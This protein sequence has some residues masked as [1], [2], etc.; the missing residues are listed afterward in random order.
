MLRTVGP[1]T[2]HRAAAPAT[3][4]S[5][6]R[7][8]WRTARPWRCG[9]ARCTTAPRTCSSSCGG[10]CGCGRWV[11]DRPYD[12]RAAAHRARGAG[13][14]SRGRRRRPRRGRAA[15]SSPRRRAR[16]A[17]SRTGSRAASRGGPAPG[18]SDDGHPSTRGP[19]RRPAGPGRSTGTLVLDVWRQVAA[20]HRDR[21]AHRNLDL[22]RVWVTPEGQAVLRGFDGAAIAA[23]DRDLALDRAQ[24]LVSTALVIGAP[25][26]R[27]TWRW[28]RSGRHAVMTAVPYLQP[29]ALPGHDPAGVARQQGGARRPAGRDRPRHRGRSRRRWPASTA[30]GPARRCRS[31][32]SRSPSTCCSRSS[33]T[34]ATTVDAASEANWWWLAPMVLGAA[35]TIVFAALAFVAS[36]P[37]PIPYLPAL[38]MQL[39][40]SFVS[41][42]A[43]ANTGHAGGRRAVPAAVGPRPRAGGGRGRADARCRASSSTCRSWAR[44]CVGRV[45][46]RAVLAARG[47]RAAHRRRGGAVGQRPGRRARARRA[48][49]GA[50]AARRAGCATRRRRW[51]TC[52][53]T[54]CG[55]SA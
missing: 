15:A 19:G 30:S 39:A 10:R 37:E 31:S 44:S 11:N 48:A 4:R 51:P 27:S 54:R 53:P 20:L 38:R 2:A 13:P 1:T 29:L 21:I 12:T 49:P 55:S 26:P 9:C 23:T 32:P 35:A 14:A 16:S 46:R 33:A 25:T 3:A 8:R 22:E 34:S 52:S 5:S 45:E 18:R 50:A 6:T 36:V 17:C 40:S 7:S 43:P 28:R 41:R 42:I 47:R 24:L